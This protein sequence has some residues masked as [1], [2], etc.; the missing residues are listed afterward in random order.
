ML[1]TPFPFFICKKPGEI[2]IFGTFLAKKLIFLSIL[3]YVHWKSAFW[4]RPCLK[5]SLW[6]HTLT[7]F[8]DFDING[9]RK[10][11][12]IPWYQTNILWA[13]QVQ[14]HKGVVTTPLGKPCYKKKGLVGRGL[15]R[16][17]YKARAPVRLR[18]PVTQESTKSL[19]ALL[20]LHAKTFELTK[21]S[22]MQ[23]VILK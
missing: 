13:R 9:K 5:T 21:P 6:R 12:P 23:V 10:P 17:F 1:E 15:I 20:V 7:D 22:I 19:K 14:V 18:L 3:V 2:P 16:P 11:Y 4:D 8:H